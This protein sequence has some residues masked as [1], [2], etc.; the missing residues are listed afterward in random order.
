MERKEEKPERR[1]ESEE[2]KKKIIVPT[3]KEKIELG[4]TDEEWTMICY[5]ANENGKCAREIGGHK[6]CE[7]CPKSKSGKVKTKD[8][9]LAKEIEKLLNTTM[10]KLVSPRR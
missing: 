9:K 7:S 8:E 6:L 2:S 3:L 5:K 1:W 10:N 4:L